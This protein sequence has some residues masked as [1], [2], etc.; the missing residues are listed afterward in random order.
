[1]SNEVERKFLIKNFPD[2]LPLK[3]TAT[4]DQGYIS[5]KLELRIRARTV[6]GEKENYKFAY[7]SKGMLSRTEIEFLISKPIYNWLKKTFI[8]FPLIN[9]LYKVYELPNGLELECSLVDRNSYNFFYY[10]EVEFHGKTKEE[11]EKLAK[12]FKPEM[13]FGDIL[14]SEVT[15]DPEWKMKNYWNSRKACM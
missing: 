4:V 9:K 8:K 2:N 10:A 6:E 5:T 14:I 12:A 15:E 13:Y 11:A 3:L 1:M 7:K